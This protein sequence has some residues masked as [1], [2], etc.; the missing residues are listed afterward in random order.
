MKYLMRL[1]PAVLS[2]WFSGSASANLLTN[3]SFEKIA[4]GQAVGWR[5]FEQGYTVA[6][7]EGR[8]GNAI[9]CVNA[10]DA[11]LRAA[12]YRATLHQTRP[13]PVL[14][15][16]WSRAEGVSG[17]SD[18]HYSIYLDAYYTD[19]TPLWGT[20]ASFPTGTHGWVKRSVIV[21]PDK[22]LQSLHI[23]ALFRRHK[24]AVWFDDFTA[25]ELSPDRLFDGQAITPPRLSK[26][27]PAGWYARD[28]AAG[29]DVLPPD[30]WSK[31]GL[32]QVSMD[33][34]PDG[35]RLV[36][37]DTTGTDRAITLYR[38]VRVP[39]GPVT[40]W[41]DTVAH[42]PVGAEEV[43]ALAQIPNTGAIGWH[44]HWPFICV[45][46]PSRGMLLG[47]P[48]T[49]GP[50]ISRF[51]YHGGQRLLVAAFDVALTASNKAH[52]IHG[53]YGAASVTAVTATFEPQ[54]GMRAA[55]ERWYSLYPEW[56]ARRATAEG[57][58]IAFTDPA[59]VEGLEDFHFAY[60][61]GTNSVASDDALGILS[62]HYTEP[63]TWWMQM[64]PDTPREYDAAMRMVSE[65]RSGTP[66]QRGWA[67]SVIHSGAQ[68]ASG[69]QVVEFINAPW[70]QGATWVLDG[71]PHLPHPD[72]EHTKFTWSFGP[73]IRAERY[74]EQK[75][76]LDGEYL[77]SIE[78]WADVLNYRP[79]SIAWSPDPPTFAS[80]SFRPVIP[81]W[82]SVWQM[83]AAMRQVLHPMNK[84][85]MANYTPWRFHQFM[86]LLDVAGTETNWFREGK[87]TPDAHSVFA[88]RR[89]LSATKPYLLLQNTDFTL[90]TT[91]YVDRYMQRCM[92]YGCYPG[93]FSENAHSNMYWTRPD[94]YN[95]DR[96][97][98]RMY[99]PVIKR[100]SSAGWRPIPFAVSAQNDV[101]I[102]R[103]GDRLLTLLHDGDGR[104]ARITLS[105]ADWPD[106]PHGASLRDLVTGEVF[107][108]SRRADSWLFTAPMRP[109]QCRALEFVAAST[110]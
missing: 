90:F 98:F 95:R 25:Q 14:V 57:Q 9:R 33:R 108:A 94:W 7:G 30:Q 2:I 100:L 102:E 59:T 16:G 29:S 44:S 36:V 27:A 110:E 61:E 1:I 70:V 80:D 28:T 31:L 73:E 99:L 22:P 105:A 53:R 41:E 21:Y 8:T 54:W 72:G 89:A 86:P 47:G 18:S 87:W 43:G 106:A 97:L 71:N 56:F 12:T 58:W 78:G 79:D 19:G 103:Y 69:Q 4:D 83:A 66:A 3:P 74:S 82:F 55:L 11:D 64:S 51:R 109:Y 76:V 96:H 92:H 65:Y 81:T 85:L 45:T 34:Q 49:Q 40:W 17:A 52:S 104:L 60:H 39:E 68:G 37:Q 63:Q 38:V 15:T 46:T 93:M 50:R 48:P 62:F 35:D 75:G 26:G 84:L 67:Q 101:R 32:R 77:D 107:A 13:I 42:R 91:D 10:S 24:G 5:P 6:R 88:L 20:I 23:H